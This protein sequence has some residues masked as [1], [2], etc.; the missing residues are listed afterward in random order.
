MFRLREGQT[1]EG[2]S[3]PPRPGVDAR[4]RDVELSALE[5]LLPDQPRFLAAVFIGNRERAGWWGS[6]APFDWADAIQA[7]RDVAAAVG[8]DLEIQ[9]GQ[10]APFH[11]GRCAQ[12]S[13]QGQVIGYAGELHPRVV[14]ATSVPARSSAFELD[15]DAL[16]DHAVDAVSAPLV[17]TQPVAK[18]DIALVV[19]GDVPAAEVA[20][21]VHEGGGDLVES[22]RLFDVY[23]GPQVPEGAKS[24]AFSLRLRAPDRTLSAE[25]ITAVRDGV[26][27]LVADR[28]GGTLR[29]S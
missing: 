17:G 6:G 19:P 22:V 4:P 15:L 21:S 14:A 18:E 24:L 13:V 16:I 23:T 20:A 28:H 10:D 25:E 12:L 5:D 3:D 7:A 29:G 9:Q 26:L 8:V 2:V 1:A 11:P 27:A